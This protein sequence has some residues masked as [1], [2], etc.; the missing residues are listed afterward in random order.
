MSIYDPRLIKRI[1]IAVEMADGEQIMFYT[2]SPGTEIQIE[3]NTEF[4]RLY[5]GMIVRPMPIGQQ[6][7]ITISGIRGYQ[8]HT[9]APEST[10][11]AIENI[12]AITGENTK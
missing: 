2:E 1:G 3:T 12:K 8:M 10:A 4:E 7:E 11:K 6:T 9:R 5:D